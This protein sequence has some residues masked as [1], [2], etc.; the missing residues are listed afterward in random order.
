MSSISTKVFGIALAT[1]LLSLTPLA[2][3]PEAGVTENAACAAGGQ[4]APE[5]NSYCIDDS[6]DP[7][8]HYYKKKMD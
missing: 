1:A 5:A 8:L 6:G 3:S 4:C 7:I 2:F